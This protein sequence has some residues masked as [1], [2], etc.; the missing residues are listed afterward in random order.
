MKMIYTYN[1][2]NYETLIKE[3]FFFKEEPLTKKRKNK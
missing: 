2:K 3:S 1:F